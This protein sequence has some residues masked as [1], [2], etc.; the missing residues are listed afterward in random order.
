MPDVSQGRIVKGVGGLY[1]IAITGGDTRVSCRAK[2]SFRHDD[3]KPYVGD[4]VKIEYGDTGDPVISEIDERKNSIIRPPLANLDLLFVV[5][6][7]KKPL[8]DLFT[9][10]KLIAIAEHNN[11]EPIIVVTKSDL[12]AQSAD[13]IESIYKKSGFRTFVCSVNENAGNTGVSELYD[14]IKE[15]ACDKIS[16]FAGASGAGKSTLMNALFPSLKIETGDVSR[17]I[18]RGRHTTR[19]VEL[20]PMSDLVGTG[21]GFFADTP[22]FTMLDFVRFDF[23][24]KE[25]LPHTFREFEDCIGKCKYT[26]CSHTKEEGCAVLGALKAGKIAESR[27]ENYVQLYNILKEKHDWDK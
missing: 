6:P 9:A 16:A 2:G 27:H 25:D 11:I 13:S 20:F 4:L 7:S 24:D 1:E 3:V 18:G 8:A 5:L 23:F 26:K 10:D 21:S 12:D 17:K 15:S 22:G 19:H 14:F